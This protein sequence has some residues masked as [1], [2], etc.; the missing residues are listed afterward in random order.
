MTNQSEARQREIE[1]IAKAWDNEGHIDDV[2]P[3][4]LKKATILVD[5]CEI[6]SV[7]RFEMN[8]KFVYRHEDEAR[9][10]IFNIKPKSYKD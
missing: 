5:E 4:T 3:D 1:K 7:E 6:G 2:H 10:L 8:P 9:S